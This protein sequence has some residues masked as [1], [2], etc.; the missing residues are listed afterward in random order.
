Q[1]VPPPLPT[2]PTAGAPA[3]P[4]PRLSASRDPT[5]KGRQADPSGE[6]R[7]DALHSTRARSRSRS[8]RLLPQLPRETPRAA[9][10]PE[11]LSE[12]P[13]S[14]TGRLLALRRE[15]LF[16]FVGLVHEREERRL[17]LGGERETG[18]GPGDPSDREQ[19]VLDEV[20]ERAGAG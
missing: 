12:T 13:H 18:S 11:A 8:A 14:A 7:A 4:G 17:L 6:S 15:L 16:F 19:P 10:G 9:T 1:A 3:R 20:R 5:R 2:V